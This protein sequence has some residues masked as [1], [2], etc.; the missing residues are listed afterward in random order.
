MRAKNGSVNKF[1]INEST[2]YDLVHT[3]PHGSKIIA[4]TI[5]SEIKK[6][7]SIN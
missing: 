6:I 3:N 7:I 2:T 4:D 5:Y 1:K